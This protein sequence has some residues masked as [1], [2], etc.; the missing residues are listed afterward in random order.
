MHFCLYRKTWWVSY[1]CQGSSKI[2]VPYLR[3]KH[4]EIIC[5]TSKDL[6]SIL[7]LFRTR[8]F[9][10]QPVYIT[11]LHHLPSQ[12]TPASV[13]QWLFEHYQDHTS[14]CGLYPL[15]NNFA[16]KNL[17]KGIKRQLGTTPK[18]K[19]PI[20]GKI[21]LDLLDQLSLC[22]SKEVSFWAC[23]CIG[24]SFFWGRQHFCLYL[25]QM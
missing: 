17:K 24:L 5:N 4:T 6:S 23:C 1:H 9:T 21:M 11:V 19:L 2:H 7:P 20:T 13:D 15:A 8:S 16:V 12:N 18:Q 22:S 25:C 14:R 10:N 3:K